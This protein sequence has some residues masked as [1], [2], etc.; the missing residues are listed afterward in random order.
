MKSRKIIRP[1]SRKHWRAYGVVLL[2]SLLLLFA[3]ERVHAQREATRTKTNVS[4]PESGAPPAST[5]SSHELTSPDVSAFVDGIVPLEIER[6]D[7]AGAVVVVVKDG[8]ILFSRGYGYSDAEKK[9]PVSPEET[10]FRVG[11]VSKLFTWTSVM[12]LQEQGKIDLDHDVN[13][14]IDFQ[15]PATLGRPITMRNL[16]TH[17]PGFEE[18]IKDLF[19]SGAPFMS[20]RDYITTHLPRQIYPPGT[21]P[22]YSNYGATL[23]GYIVQRISGRPFDD[24]VAENIFKPLEMPHSSFDQPLPE[25]L[26]DTMSK[27]YIQ[28]SGG[29]KPFEI[30]I[31]APAGSLASSGNDMAHFMIAHLQDGQYASARILRPETA[32]LM[33]TRQFSMDPSVA[34]ICLGFYEEDRNGH[35]VFGHAGDTEQFHTDL[36]LMAD[37]NLGFFVSYNSLG[38]DDLNAGTARTAL[39]HKF[40]DRYY[41]YSPPAAETLA[42]AKDDAHVVSG[43]YVSSR[44]SRTTL[45][46]ILSLLGEATVASPKNDGI[47]VMDQAKDLNGQPIRWREISPLRYRNENG[48]EEILFKRAADGHLDVLGIFPVFIS[49]SVSGATDKKL[50]LPLIL[51]SLGIILLAVLLWPIGALLRKYY[52][53]PLGFDSR[54]GRLRLLV[55]LICILDLLF[56]VALVVIGSKISN[57]IGALN[58]DLDPLIHLAQVIGLIGAIGAVIAIYYAIRVW[59]AGEKGFVFKVFDIL[60]ALACTIFAWVLF[61]THLLNFNLHY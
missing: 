40:L 56:I 42:S 29:A 16:M 2:S 27:G 46:S 60:V 23:A 35:R 39:W 24:Y 1:D 47:I 26:K 43:S 9:R 12:Q 50:L 18:V 25:P 61:F 28:A 57:D 14:Y 51:C 20:L 11:S 48:Q 22:A 34:G 8:K 41:P 30:V 6:G 45:F 38:R 37:Q 55:R 59:S 21:V 13:D 19:G 3:G 15:I 17:T 44:R 58:S 36:H 4:Q 52:K 7:I 33:H 32:R 5:A 54:T 53:K 10:Q 31:A 49:Q